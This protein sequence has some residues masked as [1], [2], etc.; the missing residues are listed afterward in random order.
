MFNLAVYK[1]SASV[2]EPNE[3]NSPEEI[4]AEIAH[5]T[6]MMYAEKK[7]ILTIRAQLRGRSRFPQG[8]QQN[9]HVPK[10]QL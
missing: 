8:I 4:E 6:M 9:K 3:P 5:L 10:W 1:E 7:R 2:N